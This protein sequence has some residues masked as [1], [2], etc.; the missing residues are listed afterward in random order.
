[1]NGC[2]DMMRSVLVG[3]DDLIDIITSSMIDIITYCHR[4]PKDLVD[5]KSSLSRVSS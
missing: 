5:Q 2:Y 1:M 3:A 4:I